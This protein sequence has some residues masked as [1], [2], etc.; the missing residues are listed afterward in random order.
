MSS[1]DTKDEV[2]S[3]ETEAVVLLENLCILPP[4]QKTHVSREQLAK[5]A[6]LLPPISPS[7][8]IS[9]IRAAIGE[10]KDYAHITNYHL[11]LEDLDDSFID[12]VRSETEKKIE[13]IKEREAQICDSNNHTKNKI[14][15]FSSVDK[16]IISPYTG[17]SACVEISPF[18]AVSS[19]DEEKSGEV[20]LCLNDFEDFSLIVEE[21]KMRSNIG[22]RIVLEKYDIGKIKAHVDRTRL[23]LHGNAPV[24]VALPGTTNATPIG[25]DDPSE[26]DDTT[27]TITDDEKNDNQVSLPEAT[28]YMYCDW[29][30]TRLAFRVTV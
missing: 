17:E 25:N 5:D 26:S 23:L 11:V 4:R 7:E 13:S 8:P 19:R 14:A 1:E 18:L 9:S 6:I 16:E 27:K 30:L 20:E 2:P 21:G 29:Y 3:L 28:D 24:V 15:K 22:I 12:L 10:I